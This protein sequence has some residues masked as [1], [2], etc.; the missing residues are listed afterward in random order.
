MGGLIW[1]GI[2]RLEDCQ[3]WREPLLVG[4]WGRNLTGGGGG[5]EDG[6]AWH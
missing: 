4:N 6:E 3:D 1:L 5:G 2:R